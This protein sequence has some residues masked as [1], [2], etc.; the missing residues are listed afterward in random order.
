MK[1]EDIRLTYT[2]PVT[3]DRESRDAGRQYVGIDGVVFVVTHIYRSR[4][5]NWSAEAFTEHL[6]SSAALEWAKAGH[7][8]G[9]AHIRRRDL[10]AQIVATA[11]TE[12]WKQ[13]RD[14][15]LAVPRGRWAPRRYSI[16]RRG[17]GDWWAVPRF[18][19]RDSER[20][21]YLSEETVRA[22][23]GDSAN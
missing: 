4:I 17:V 23:L 16:E 1:P 12:E 11:G 14:A 3:G 18:P 20:G 19:A 22:D 2:N 10:L 6:E 13:K 8:F 7:A 21:P 5:P 15:W 9:F